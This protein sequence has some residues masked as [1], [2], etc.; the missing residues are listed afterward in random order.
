M[1]VMSDLAWATYTKRFPPDKE[2]GL[3]D[4]D[5]HNALDRHPECYQSSRVEAAVDAASSLIALTV[6]RAQRRLAEEIVRMTKDKLHSGGR[7]ANIPSQEAANMEKN[8]RRQMEEAFED[9][10]HLRFTRAPRDP[11][12]P[13]THTSHEQLTEMTQR[14]TTLAGMRMES[15]NESYSFFLDRKSVAQYYTAS[16]A[17]RV[18]ARARRLSTR[19]ICGPDDYAPSTS[20]QEPPDE[21]NSPIQTEQADQGDE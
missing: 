10:V 17:T 19:L 14:I 1:Q 21:P 8:K 20:T 16:I 9:L 5:T 11:D 12:M 13:A 3:S 2:A 15:A 6:A 7:E 18:W 4:E